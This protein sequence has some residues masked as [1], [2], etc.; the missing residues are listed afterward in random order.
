MFIH[1]GEDTI[2]RTSEVVAIFDY[3]RMKEDQSNLRLL[4]NLKKDKKV[5]NVSDQLAKS[6]VFT[7]HTVY[8]SPFSPATLKRRSQLTINP[9]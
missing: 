2:V 8:L 5:N 9:S 1:L 3:E 4:E 6:V 7:D